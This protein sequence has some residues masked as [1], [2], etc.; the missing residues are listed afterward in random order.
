MM[1]PNIA[2][3]RN[4]SL[5]E[6]VSYLLLLFIGMPLK[7]GLGIRSINMILGMGHGLVTM[8]FC[9]TLG[10]IW[11]RKTL[12]TQ[13]CITLFIASLVPFGAFLADKKLKN[14]QNNPI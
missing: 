13:W 12:S 11:I 14:L 5:I 6:G 4:I 3:L 1:K 10:A 7:Y 8:I 2:T 9:L